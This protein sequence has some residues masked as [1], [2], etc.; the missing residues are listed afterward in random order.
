MICC[1]VVEFVA[2]LADVMKDVFGIVSERWCRYIRTAYSGVGPAK[3]AHSSA[4]SLSLSLLTCKRLRI[5][6]DT[7]TA[8]PLIQ[9]YRQ[10]SWTEIRGHQARSLSWSCTNV[11]HKRRLTVDR[12]N[13]HIVHNEKTVHTQP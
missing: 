2:L 8:S 9:P 13:G 3:K 4:S 5:S 12:I 10:S 11:R 7:F 1:C 6:I